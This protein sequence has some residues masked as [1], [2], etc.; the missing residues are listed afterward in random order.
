MSPYLRDKFELKIYIKYHI[1]NVQVHTIHNAVYKIYCRAH[2]HT[3]T[4]FFYSA[5]RSLTGKKFFALPK[6]Q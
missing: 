1:Y 4:V 3:E 2:T 6:L 5:L